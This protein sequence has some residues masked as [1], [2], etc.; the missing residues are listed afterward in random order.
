M[1]T[2][3]S[4]LERLFVSFGKWMESNA[5]ALSSGLAAGFLAH[6]FVLSNK[7]MNADEVTALFSKGATVDSGRWGLE[8]ATLL[9]PNVSLPWL[10]GILSLVMLSI[11]AGLTIGIFRIE[12]KLFRVLLPAVIVSFPAV[13]G[14]F[15]FMFTSSAY[16]LAFMLAVLAVYAFIKLDGVWAWI[17]SVTLLTLSLGIYQAYIAITA[18]F[19]IILMIQKLYRREES[20]RE[21]FLYG[22]RCVAMLAA[23]LAVYALVTVLVTKLSGGEF[24]SYAGSEHSLLHRVRLAYTSFIRIFISGY[25]G[26]VNSAFSA[27][28][29]GIG[30]VLVL[31]MLLHW[32]IRSGL[33]EAGLMLLC[34]VLLPLGIDCIF[35]IANTT[36]IHSLVLNGFISVYVLAA[37]LADSMERPGKFICKDLA[38]AVLILIV[39][40]NIFFANKV[41][42]KMHLQYENAF[43]YYTELVHAL[44]QNENYDENLPVVIAGNESSVMHHPQLDTGRLMGPNEDLINIYTKECFIRYYI[45]VDLP[46]AEPVKYYSL[47]RDERVAAM[48]EYPAEGCIQQ[49]DEHI[50]IKI[51]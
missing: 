14:V 32:F 50:V 10:W 51:G 29:H 2:N 11:S 19:F 20:A 17:A 33:K 45:G 44:R 25:F 15:C 22:L 26:Y 31:F 18:S 39:S 40:C 6:M 41:Y 47:L 36:V 4:P 1:Q 7:L 8:L 43:A 23:T 16:F 5:L 38:S 46:V 49:I 34:I 28:M 37:V 27:I 13:T 48:P 30:L 42:L 12:S 21:V 9:F 35:L 3:N 24:I